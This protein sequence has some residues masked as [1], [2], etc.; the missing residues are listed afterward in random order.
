ML[1]TLFAV[2]LLVFVAF[3]LIPGDPALRRLGTEGTPAQLQAL[4]EE[5]GLNAPLPERYFRWARGFLTG[6]MGTSYSNAY[7]VSE[8]IGGKIP[9]TVAL[10]LIALVI[11]ILIS[12]PL[13]VYCAKYEGFLID[14]I[15]LV[16]NQVVMSIPPF[17]SGVLLSALFGKV[18]RW[19]TPGAYVHYTDSVT[20]FLGYM[21]LPAFCVALPKAA[22]TTKL[23]RSSMLDEASKDY[24]RTAYS[25]GN[26]VNRVMYAHLLRNAMIPVVTFLGM[27]LADMVAGSIVVE[28]IFSIPG[29]SNTLITS[30]S[31]RDYPV[32]QAVI[33]GVAMTVMIINLAVDLI[34]RILD[35]RLKA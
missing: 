29:I 7:P 12:F 30:I 2:S 34:Y 21:L 32:V 14:R 9:V 10:A 4:R 33:V 28:T 25:R 19:F 17:F 3:S 22:M 16:L 31:N 11:T 13:G 26:T 23:L 18:L 8:L 35:P 24:T 1:V 15:V 27:S 5:M 20:G 6:D